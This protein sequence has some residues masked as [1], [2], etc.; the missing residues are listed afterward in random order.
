VATVDQLGMPAPAAVGIRVGAIWEGVYDIYGDFAPE[1][2][3][4][5]FRFPVAFSTVAPSR[6]PPPTTMP[7]SATRTGCTVPRVKR[8]RAAKARRHMRAAGCRYRVRRVRSG[9]RAGRVVSTR[10]RAGRR[11]TKRV[12]IRVSRGRA[13]AT[14]AQVGAFS[15]VARALSRQVA[16]GSGD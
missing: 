15:V 13:R 6:P 14:S 7:P 5:S 16:F 4:P 10:P 11:T 12:V 3:D 2:L 8:L 1:V 9:I